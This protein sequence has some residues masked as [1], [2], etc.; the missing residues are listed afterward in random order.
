[1]IAVFMSVVVVDV[2]VDVDVEEDED[3]GVVNDDAPI[4]GK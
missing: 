2:D 1:M 4:V 3:D